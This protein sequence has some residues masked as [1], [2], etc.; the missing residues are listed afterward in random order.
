VGSLLAPGTP[1]VLEASVTV[2]VTLLTPKKGA[3]RL[4]GFVADELVAF[5]LVVLE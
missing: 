5:R 2:H 1:R 3:I 4:A